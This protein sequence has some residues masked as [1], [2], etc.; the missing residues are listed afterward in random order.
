MVPKSTREKMLKNTRPLRQWD[1]WCF[2]SACDFTFWGSGWQIWGQ[3]KHQ[4]LF[5][6]QDPN[7]FQHSNVMIQFPNT[8]PKFHSSPLKAMVVGRFRSFPKLGSFNFSGVNSLLN[9]G[10]VL[11]RSLIRLQGNQL[12][13]VQNPGWLGYIRAYT[14][15][16][17]RDYFIS[18]YKDPY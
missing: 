17:Y 13:S 7:A 16:L 8:P 11:G 15:Q 6:H 14:T 4:N 1:F 3:Q 12:S 2:L 18:Y 10:R 9:F 5:K